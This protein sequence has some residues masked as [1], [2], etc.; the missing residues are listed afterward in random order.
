MNVK[1]NYDY[2]VQNKE[3]SIR[4]KSESGIRKWEEMWFKTTAEDGERE[5][6]G[7]Q[8]RVME[9]CSTDERLQQETLC[10]WQW[11]D[12]RTSRDVDEA[13]RSHSMTT[14]II[15]YYHY[16]HYYC[17]Y[18]LEAKL[19]HQPSPKDFQQMP[20]TEYNT[21]HYSTTTSSTYFY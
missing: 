7:Q 11:T 3:E 10:R 9:D 5:G 18:Y 2:T 16:N 14:A 4:E 12:E 13:E 21:I 19:S 1:C 20:A 6:G 8:W 17:Y 15:T